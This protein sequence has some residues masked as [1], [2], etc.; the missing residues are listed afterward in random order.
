MELENCYLCII[1]GKLVIRNRAVILTVEGG[2]VD[3]FSTH[4]RCWEGFVIA[5]HLANENEQNWAHRRGHQEKTSVKT[6]ALDSE[7]VLLSYEGCFCGH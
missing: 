7:S 2:V 5:S 3:W 6:P 4:P 1:A